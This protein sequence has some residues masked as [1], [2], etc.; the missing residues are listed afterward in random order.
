ME[1]KS[2]HI[3]GQDGAVN[4]HGI[5]VES[6]STLNIIQQQVAV[7]EKMLGDVQ[8]QSWVGVELPEGV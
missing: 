6:L 3:Y 4:E 8:I 7:K 1:I 2:T 5:S